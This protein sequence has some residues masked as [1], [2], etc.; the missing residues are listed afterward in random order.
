[1]IEASQHFV[2][3]N[4]LQCRV[5]ERIAELTHNE[6]AYVTS[7]AA[8]GLVLATAVCIAGNNPELVNRFPNLDGLKNEVIIHKT[9]RNGYDYAVVTL[10]SR[11]LY[12]Q[13]RTV[14]ISY[15]IPGSPPRS[16]DLSRVGKGYASLPVAAEGDAGP[17]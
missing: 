12:G 3:L 9:Q 8:A 11:L 1:M 2:D 16:A 7:G 6:A 10:P 4:E 13:S 15:E 17:V 5:G 14:T